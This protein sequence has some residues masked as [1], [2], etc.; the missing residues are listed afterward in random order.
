M[1][2]K[3]QKYTVTIESC[4]VEGYGVCRLDGRAVF[5]SGVLPGE[6]WEV[7]ILKVTN[8]AVWA[9]GTRMLKASPDRIPNTC[10]NPCGGC[11]LRC[12]RYPAE[13]TVKKQHVDDC[14]RRLGGQARGTDCIHPSPDT[15]RCRNKAVFAVG[16]RDGKAVFGFYRPRSHDIVPVT[17]CLLQS[18]R[19][20]QAA[21][22]VI[23]FM[24][25]EGISAYCE[26]T[27]RGTVR[28]L[29]WRESDRDAVLCITAARGFGSRTEDLV[30][31]LRRACPFLTGIVLNVNKSRLNTVLAGE[32]YTLW[33]RETVRQRFCG[34]DFEVQPQAF[35]QVNSLQAEAIYR[36][37][38]EWAIPAGEEPEVLD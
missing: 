19:C 24:N 31:F 33:G 23:D 2:S 11:S 15:D 29:L 14:L 34:V 22:A 25:R 12:L 4:T 18:E 37:V 10:P 5:V 21:K 36:K 20:L 7:L 26:E 38:C 1:L 8:T 35:L 3:N 27:G 13:L 30:G 28:H 16:D 32:F 6:D 9:K 17:D